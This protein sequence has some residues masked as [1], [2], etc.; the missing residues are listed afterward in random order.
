MLDGCCCEDVVV[1]VSDS[2]PNG[3]QGVFPNLSTAVEGRKSLSRWRGNF[4]LLCYS[5]TPVGAMRGAMAWRLA[6]A[7]TKADGGRW[8]K[9]QEKDRLCNGCNLQVQVPQRSRGIGEG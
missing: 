8:I 2:I 7:V 1:F 5:A 3:G 4:L 6:L 9:K